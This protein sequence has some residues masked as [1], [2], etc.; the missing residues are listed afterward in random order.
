[1]DFRNAFTAGIQ[2]GGLT[3]DFEVQVFVCYLLQHIGGPVSFS[4]LSEIVQ[5]DGMVNYFEFASAISHLK[6]AEKLEVTMLE[7]GEEA[8]TLTEPGVATA[9]TFEYSV[10]LTI[11]EK[12]IEISGA[13]FSNKRLMEENYVE[14]Q[15]VADGYQ[16]T[17]VVSDVGS[18]LMRLTLFAPDLTQCESI[19]KAFLKNPVKVYQT[20]LEL[21]TGDD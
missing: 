13:F 8:Y 3:N 4:Q 12:G 16:V 19:Q 9:K 17:L 5:T 7:S 15:E 18:D 14:I 21:F 20:V 2:P 10:P 6:E 1:M 11:R